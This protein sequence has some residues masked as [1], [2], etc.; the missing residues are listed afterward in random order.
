MKQFFKTFVIKC[1][2]FVEVSVFSIMFYVLCVM[3][4]ILFSPHIA[5]VITS[6]RIK[7]AIKETKEKGDI[8]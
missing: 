1:L 5:F 3:G 2:L 8:E 6:A 7:R 4:V